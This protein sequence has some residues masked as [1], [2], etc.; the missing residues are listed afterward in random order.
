MGFSV[1][2]LSLGDPRFPAGD[3]L[4]GYKQFFGQLVLRQTPGCAELKN[5]ILWFHAYHLM[6]SI[7]RVWRAGKQRAVAAV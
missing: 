2:S 5:D 7:L 1:V 6:T 4:P 3:G